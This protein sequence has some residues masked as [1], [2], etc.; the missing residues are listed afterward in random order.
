LSAAVLGIILR[1][2]DE[3]MS[4]GL[5]AL[6]AFI[7]I[8]V[9]FVLM[10]GFRWPSTKAMPVAWIV[11]VAL[12]A[13]VWGM[14]AQWIA[15]A[16]INGIFNALKIL[17]IVFGAILLLQ[18]LKTSGAMAS[19]N[20]GFTRISP[21]RRVQAIIIGWL[22]GAFLE[23]AAGFGTPAAI[24]AP[25]L[26]GMGFP[27]LA[28]VLVA[29][30]ANSTP[31][32]FGAVGTP[33]IVGMEAALNAPVVAEYL[34]EGLALA[35]YV[36][37]VGVAA[38]IP[39]AIIG[40]LVPLLMI[41]ML[42]AFFGEGKNR[43]FKKGLE[44][45]PFAIFAGLAFTIPYVLVAIL[46]GPEFPSLIGALIGLGVVVLAA[47]KGFL[48]PKE[49]WDFPRRSNWEEDWVG[50]EEP[51]SSTEKSTIPLAKAWIPYVLVGLGLVATRVDFLP[52]KA[53]IKSVLIFKVPDIL[54]TGLAFS[55]P[56]LDLPGIIPFIPVALLAIPIFKMNSRQVS[57]AFGNTLRQVK[58]A[59]ISLVFAVALVQVMVQSGHN[60]LGLESMV[61]SMATAVANLAG[62]SWPMFAGVVGVLGAFVSG[63]NTVSDMLFGL[64]QFGTAAK[65]GLPTLVILGLQAVG[66]AVGN[67]ICVNNV[68]AACST[69][70]IVGKEGVLIKRNL[71]PVVIYIGL[72]GIL[73][74][75][76]VY[77]FNLNL[78]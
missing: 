17:V 44:I 48:T 18:V 4:I 10:V 37:Q 63:S 74:I 14:N 31:V 11:A 26:L 32:T 25:L 50:V 77:V 76:A 5:L 66:G 73:G 2:A 22:F 7:P 65:L 68:V 43:S 52:F 75:L 6:V 70:G 49:V 8:L 58:P 35:D 16:S 38:A 29:L 30:I 13:L 21:D 71:I 3:I 1:E 9:V 28:A 45:W 69:V 64:F 33:I 39:H 46:L 19:I 78:I 47:S 27:P 62:G 36:R 20:N 12:A 67:M 40:T 42:T 56:I 51:G 24:A 61:M 15:A 59:A 41:C 23:G 60:A 72:A 55:Q 57:Q 34:P 53:W 54:G